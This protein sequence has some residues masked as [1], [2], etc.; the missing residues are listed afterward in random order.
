MDQTNNNQSPYLITGLG[1]PGRQYKLNRHNIG[2]MLVNRLAERLDI[3]FTRMESRALVTKH[4]FQNRSIILAKPQTFMNLSG[5][6]VG[7]LVKYYKIPLENLLIAYDEVDLP[8][9]VI[10][11]R[12]SGGSAGQKG[13]VSIIDRLGSED[14][15]RLRLGVGRPPGRMNAGS[16]VLHDFS[17]QE[18]EFLPEFLDR[19]VEAVQTFITQGLVEAMNRY[20]GPG[21][22]DSD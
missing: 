20:N 5:Q 1:N 8:L 7:A 13:M 6:A 18:V 12:P 19:G 2:F 14:F 9:G 16:Y 17:R 4:K 22:E 15:P 10:R 21:Y 11:L 3:A